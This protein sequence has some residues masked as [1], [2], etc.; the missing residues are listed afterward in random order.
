MALRLGDFEEGI[1]LTLEGLAGAGG[2]GAQHSHAVF[3]TQQPLRGLR[4]V[5]AN[6]GRRWSTATRP[7]GLKPNNWHAY[8][9]RAVHA[10]PYRAT[11]GKAARGPGAGQAHQPRCKTAQGSGGIPRMRARAAR[12][13]NARNPGRIRRERLRSCCRPANRSES[14]RKSRGWIVSHARIRVHGESDMESGGRSRGRE[15]GEFM[16]TRKEACPLRTGGRICWRSGKV[17][18]GA[19]GRYFLQAGLRRGGNPAI[20]AARRSPAISC[21]ACRRRFPGLPGDWAP[22]STAARA[23]TSVT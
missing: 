1:R 20:R 11:S 2:R 16:L 21:S 13:Q 12:G 6:S 4:D 19:A 15:A 22:N 9:N 14:D 17:R 23:P 18:F 10:Y 7:C 8:S 3:R 5:A